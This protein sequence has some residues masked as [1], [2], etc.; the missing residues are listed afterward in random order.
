M[1]MNFIFILTV[2]CP[3]PIIPLRPTIIA[4]PVTPKHGPPWDAL[5]AGINRR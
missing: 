5:E 4:G 2:I 1:K 3:V